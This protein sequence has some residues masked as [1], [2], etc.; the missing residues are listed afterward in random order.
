MWKQLDVPL[1]H[2]APEP[3][4][5]SQAQGEAGSCARRGPLGSSPSV[6]GPRSHGSDK[7]PG[8]GSARP[9][10]TSASSPSKSPAFP[11]PLSPSPD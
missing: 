10:V 1:S 5:W 7:V 6:P 2:P 4:V 11:R 9:P 3:A 8:P